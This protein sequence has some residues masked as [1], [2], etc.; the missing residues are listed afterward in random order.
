M[1]QVVQLLK[2]T[3]AHN[4]KNLDGTASP[5]DDE[6]AA[7]AEEAL[8]KVLRKDLFARLNRI[9]EDGG[10]ALAFTNAER[11]TLFQAHP[12]LPSTESEVQKEKLAS[13]L[14]QDV[15]DTS[16]AVGDVA[17]EVTAEVKKMQ[18]KHAVVR[19]QT[20][21]WHHD[22]G[23]G[24][25]NSVPLRASRIL[26]QVVQFAHGADIVGDVASALPGFTMVNGNSSSSS[27]SDSKYAKGA[28]SLGSLDYAYAGSNNSWTLTDAYAAQGSNHRAQRPSEAARQLRQLDVSRKLSLSPNAA[29]RARFPWSPASF[30][31][32]GKN[33]MYDAHSHDSTGDVFGGMGAGALSGLAAKE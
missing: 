7:V 20:G 10:R 28:N 8:E 18:K 5:K 29:T 12:D 13:D 27:S 25:R 14:E 16:K 31:G 11:A 17:E 24:A 6:L 1:I 26:Q 2:E 15:D 4:E 22:D 32:L 21:E 9:G 3:A 30:V 33:K 23:Q 19:S